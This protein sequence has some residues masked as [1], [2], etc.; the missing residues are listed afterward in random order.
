MKKDL[1]MNVF[2]SR[3]K[4]ARLEKGM[5]Q[6]ELSDLTG[7]ST[8]MISSYERSDAETG[9]N[10]SL[11]NV[12]LLASALGMSI[13]WLCGRGEEMAYNEHI[14]YLK[15]FIEC[16]IYFDAENSVYEK[17]GRNGTVSRIEDCYGNHVWN[18]PLRNTVSVNEMIKDI[19]VIKEILR[20][21]VVT[22]DI[23][24]ILIE[25]I[26]KKY[27][28][29]PLSEIFVKN[30]EDNYKKDGDPNAHNPET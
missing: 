7:I 21:G 14:D 20:T 4:K 5:T 17:I 8:V 13:D 29:V 27:K 12:Y 24:H 19:N 30:P 22:K 25:N 3:L 6:K 28:A 10:P 18:I 11:N 9:K 2:G 1:D 15:I 23:L 16:S 26:Y